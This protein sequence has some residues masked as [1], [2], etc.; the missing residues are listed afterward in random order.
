MLRYF[1]WLSATL[2]FAT[3]LS[4]Q[5]D[6]SAQTSGS[7]DVIISTDRPAVAESSV[8]VPLGGLQVENGFLLTDASGQRVVDF[9][10]SNFRYGLLGKTEL[11][12]AAPDYFA[13]VSS[14]AGAVS[15]F[16]D[17]ALGVK[18]QLG[19]IAGFDVSLIVFLSFPSGSKSVSSHGY[20]PGLQIPWSRSLSKKWTA[21]GQAA[22]YWPTAAGSH[23]FTPET[24][25][26]VD[27]QLTKPWDAFLEW[28]GDFPDRGGNRQQLHVGTAYKLAPHHQIDFHFAFG[29]TPAASKAYVGLGYSFLISPRR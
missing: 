6:A 28:A 23:N 29:L 22:F 10:E 26:F 2:V 17:V 1:S 3:A 20:D 9:T 5:S 21:G 18:Q 25:V 4:A 13:T 11:R 15:G 19:P 16:A 8:V 7:A 12:L 27:R 24:T 14:G